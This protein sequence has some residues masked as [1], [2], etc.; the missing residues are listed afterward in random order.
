[1]RQAESRR[2]LARYRGAVVVAPVAAFVVPRGLRQ[3]ILEYI[4]ELLRQGTAARAARL[5]ECEC[6]IPH[7]LG[8]GVDYFAPASTGGRRIGQRIGKRTVTVILQPTVIGAGRVQVQHQPSYWTALVQ[9][10]VIL[11]IEA[12]V[13]KL[14][15]RDEP[16]AIG[17]SQFL[18]NPPFRH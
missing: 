3:H 12:A 18:N 1:M 8:Y 7:S 5:P 10:I 15:F 9:S 17:F 6:A 14:A 2:V 4:L 13:R 11:G 16:C